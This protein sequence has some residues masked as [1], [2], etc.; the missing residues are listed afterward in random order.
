MGEEV[1][2]TDPSDPGGEPSV[3]VK[4]PRI[5]RPW[6]PVLGAGL[7]LLVA[8]WVGEA[9]W[10]TQTR[11]QER[12]R[13]LI[14][15]ESQEAAYD[16]EILAAQCR[17][18]FAH[19]RTIPMILASKETVL[20]RLADFG[21]DV[22]PSP[23]A[24]EDRNRLWRADPGLAQL[25][26]QL[27]ALIGRRDITARGLWVMNA[28]G[29][30]IAI[31]APVA[32]VDYTGANYSD[33]A[34]FK[35]ARMGQDGQQF[36]LGKIGKIPGFFFTSPVMLGGHFLGAIGAR[37]NLADLAERFG[38]DT[39][40]TDIHGVII[41]AHDPDLRMK[42]VPGATVEA[43]S[44]DERRGRY[45]QETFVAVDLQRSPKEGED[46]AYRRLGSDLPWIHA[47]RD[48]DLV[49]VHVLRELTSV[50]SLRDDQQ[51]W[52]V[53]SSV[54]GFFLLLFGAACVL[55]VLESRRHAR[56][57]A[58]QASTDV[59]TGCAN[60]RYFLILLQAE[61]QR[62]SRYR[63]DFCL[64]ALD[65]DHFKQVNDHYGHQGGDV[66]LCR[67]AA[68]TQTLLRTTDHVGRLGGEEF[69]V[70]LPR[71]SVLEATRIAERLRRTLAATPMKVNGAEFVVT[72]SIGVA[73][74]DASRQ[75]TAEDM[76]IR[77][78]EALYR[79]K[80]NGRNRVEVSSSSPKRTPPL[81]S[82]ASGGHTSPRGVS[83][84][85][86]PGG[87]RGPPGPRSP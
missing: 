23:L 48:G 47:E 65:L 2:R 3:A 67:F 52:F 70:L 11:A 29:D 50:A 45:Q 60:R 73:C 59:L 44:A 35:Q 80:H 74:W 41:Y 49:T 42:V 14:A 10:L 27:R 62:A 38:P 24:P 21:P 7:I 87:P 43:L 82:H 36:A 4:K 13:D 61:V 79:A 33:R 30:T 5:S 81:V 16:A 69:S 58:Q 1:P 76:L 8:A 68:M 51:R 77:A 22:L 25:A 28:A 83:I 46:G 19:V 6:G 55:Y 15:R 57:L 71:T 26:A 40:L 63:E 66:A 18:S 9:W 34:Y 20:A 53:L 54:A 86:R 17:V 39:F 85:P 84:T 31:A 75:E 64:L 37:V 78:D 72:V 12:L 56:H 32:G